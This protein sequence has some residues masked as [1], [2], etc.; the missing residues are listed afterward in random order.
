MCFEEDSKLP[1]PPPPLHKEC[2]KTGES[3][4][5]P[6]GELESFQQRIFPQKSRK[7]LL[8]R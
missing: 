1:P 7:R 6:A 5:K 3:D 8:E 4:I 2:D